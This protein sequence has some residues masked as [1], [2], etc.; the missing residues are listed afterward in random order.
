M[1]KYSVLMAVYHK[2]NPE[3]F[4]RACLSML[5]QTISPNEFVLVCDGPLG[6]DL[7][8]KIAKL[9][10]RYSNIM[11]IVRIPKNM[12]LGN[13]LKCGVLHCKNE[14]IARMDADDISSPNRCEKQLHVFSK[15]SKLAIIGTQVDEVTDRGTV[16]KHIVPEEHSCISQYAKNR[17]PFC[18][19]SVMFVRN[20]VLE[21]GNYRDVKLFEDYDLWI[22][23][24]RLGHKGY[25]IQESL[26]KMNVD[27]DFYK[28]RGG[29]RYV[30]AI[31]AFNKIKRHHGVPCSMFNTISRIIVALIPSILREKLYQSKI[32]RS[33]V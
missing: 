7:D 17:N 29:I 3:D 15:N 27:R 10:E 22:R 13:A 1:Y 28:R 11:H 24:L 12:G 32:M 26:V 14:L 33:S 9:A 6:E 2:D 5:Q 4:E 30:K 8:K 20:A 23:M 19:P 21:S 18:H 25:N 16:L 31:F